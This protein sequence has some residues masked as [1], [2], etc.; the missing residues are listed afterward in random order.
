M[1]ALLQSSAKIEGAERIFDNVYLITAKPVFEQTFSARP[2]PKLFHVYLGYAGWTKAQLQ[3]EV[4]LGAWFIFPADTKTVF[5]A[6][7]GSLWPQMIRQT[8][9]KMAW[10]YPRNLSLAADR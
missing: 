8:E 9:L 7:P 10:N 2:D 6:D 5:N 1:F 4:D 3:K